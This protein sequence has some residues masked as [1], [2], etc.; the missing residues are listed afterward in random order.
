VTAPCN[1]NRAGVAYLRIDYDDSS[2]GVPVVSCRL[3]GNGQGDAAPATIF[4]G[5]TACSDGSRGVLSVSC[6]LNG[7]PANVFEGIIASKGFVEF[8][9]QSVNDLIANGRIFH[10]VHGEEH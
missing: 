5:I 3:P 9:D 1:D 8:W 6:G 10:V 4:E 7:T 2:K